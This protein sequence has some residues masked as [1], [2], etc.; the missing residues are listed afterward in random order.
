MNEATEYHRLLRFLVQHLEGR[1][2]LTGRHDGL[3]DHGA[4][5]TL[6]GTHLVRAGNVGKDFDHLRD[7]ELVLTER[8][9][10]VT[11]DEERGEALPCTHYDVMMLGLL[12]VHTTPLL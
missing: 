9:V 2:P 5:P 12:N 8:T 1:H 10:D 7:S 4:I 11:G 3:L 6:D